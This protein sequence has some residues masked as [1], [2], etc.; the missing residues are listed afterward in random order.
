MSKICGRCPNA[1]KHVCSGCKRVF[2]CGKKC[3]RDDWKLHRLVCC[4]FPLVMRVLISIATSALRA[5]DHV[6]VL[7][8]VD[9]LGSRESRAFVKEAIKSWQERG[10]ANLYVATVSGG[11]RAIK[12]MDFDNVAVIARSMTTD[13]ITDAQSKL[14]DN[15]TPD[16]GVITALTEGWCHAVSCVLCHVLQSKYECQV[17][18]TVV[19]TTKRITMCKIP[20]ASGWVA[21]TSPIVQQL[22]A[23]SSANGE[24]RFHMGHLVVV[25]LLGS[26]C[27]LLD[28]TAAQ[29]IAPGGA[30][31][32][33]GLAY[34]RHL[35]A[36]PVSVGTELVVPFSKD[37][38]TYRFTDLRQMEVSKAELEEV[39]CHLLTNKQGV[40]GIE[41][42]DVTKHILQMVNGF[43][44]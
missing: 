39:F 34:V 33:E 26:T 20:I 4:V 31:D 40:F 24:T 36:D 29:F 1:A 42:T 16:I 37:T 3:Q 44:L 11:T 22:K 9:Q 10:D 2:Y 8:V 28:L 5:K 14:D 32:D 27:I 13:D 6:I 41:T 21:T 23:S 43:K 19:S 30:V 18:G 7:M 12:A 25:V 38:I 35:F 15:R 17:W